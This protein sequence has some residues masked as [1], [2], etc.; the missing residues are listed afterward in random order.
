M[1]F[2]NAV[3]DKNDASSLMEI[4]TPLLVGNAGGY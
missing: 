1:N 2:S 3:M 4:E